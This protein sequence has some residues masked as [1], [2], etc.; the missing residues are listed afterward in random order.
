MM[1]MGMSRPPSRPRSLPQLVEGSIHLVLLYQA[2]L[3]PSELDTATQF[4]YELILTI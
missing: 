3:L 2:V 4:A 1:A